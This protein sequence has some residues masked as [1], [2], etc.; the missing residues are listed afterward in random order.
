VFGGYL[1]TLFLLNVSSGSK[2]CHTRLEILSLLVPNQNLGDLTS[3]NVD[4]KC[5]NHP[6]TRC[7]VVAYAVGSDINVFNGRP[8]L[9]FVNYAN[10][11]YKI[12]Y[13]HIVIFHNFSCGYVF[14]Y[15]MYFLLRSSAVLI[16]LVAVVAAH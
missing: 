11:G 3:F 4:L 7:T 16:S 14:G 13:V 8:V 2:C 15:Y 1:Y 12:C 5:H 10:Y 6:S 9:I